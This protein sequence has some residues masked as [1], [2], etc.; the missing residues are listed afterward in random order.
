MTEL[1]RFLRHAIAPFVIYAVEQG[2]LPKSAQSDVIE[3]AVIAL[4]F[5]IPYGWSWI[6][7]RRK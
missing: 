4:G 1:L 5:A 7:D 3:V 2:W 6:K